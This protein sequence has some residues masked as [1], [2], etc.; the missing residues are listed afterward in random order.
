M[1]IYTRTGDQGETGLFG[2]KRVSK[3]ELRV[4]AYGTVDE[5]NAQLGWAESLVRHLGLT[6]ELQSVQSDFLVIGADLATP[7]EASPAA[8]A[9][10]R[11]IEAAQVTRLEGW[12]DRFEGETAPLT[13]FILPGGAPG[14][15]A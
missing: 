6:Q 15:A 9:R 13:T 2:G 10:T 8:A 12:I 7:A 4:E 5:L 1:R 11:R 14:A 3:A